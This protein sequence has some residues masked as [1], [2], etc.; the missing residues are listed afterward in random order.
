MCME[1]VPGPRSKRLQAMLLRL[2]FLE[3][4]FHPR[5]RLIIDSIYQNGEVFKFHKIVRS[6]QVK[7]F[8]LEF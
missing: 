8:G 6:I 1:I 7:V 2:L 3:D 4:F 5:L